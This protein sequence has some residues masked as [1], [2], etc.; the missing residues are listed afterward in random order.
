MWRD[1]LTGRNMNALG[2]AKNLIPDQLSWKSARHS[3]EAPIPE[4]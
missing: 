4:Q 1:E 3:V 2:H